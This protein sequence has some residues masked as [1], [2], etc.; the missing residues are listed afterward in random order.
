MLHYNIDNQSLQVFYQFYINKLLLCYIF[1]K[2][3]F[4][5]LSI[6]VYKVVF[7]WHRNSFATGFV[8]VRSVTMRDYATL[9]KSNDDTLHRFD[10]IHIL[11]KSIIIYKY[12]GII[13]SI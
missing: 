5:H 10:R 2:Q 13:L 4:V 6:D 12:I 11:I 1:Q 8:T 9:G 3:G 7:V